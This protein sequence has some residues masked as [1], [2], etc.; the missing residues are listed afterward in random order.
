M[1]PLPSNF[2]PSGMV[3]YT[4]MRKGYIFFVHYSFYSF[5]MCHLFRTNFSPNHDISTIVFNNESFSH[6]V[7]LQAGEQRSIY[8]W[9]IYQILTHRK[10]K[11]FLNFL[12]HFICSL[13]KRS[14][15]ATRPTIPKGRSERLTTINY[16]QEFFVHNWN[17]HSTD[18]NFFSSN[19]YYR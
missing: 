15:L 16:W 5:K 19:P 4:R 10:T 13:V 3:R 6:S 1:K 9:R 11:L 18:N 7:H 17:L 8:C 12:N 14:F 2:L